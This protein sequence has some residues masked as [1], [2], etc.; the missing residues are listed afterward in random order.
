M[1]GWGFKRKLAGFWAGL[2]LCLGVD[3]ISKNMLIINVLLTINK[4]GYAM[5]IKPK[6]REISLEMA[7]RFYTQ[8]KLAEVIGINPVAVSLILNGKNGVSQETAEKI[9]N[10]FEKSFDQL[11][12]LDLPFSDPLPEV[13]E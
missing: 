1:F 13:V 3:I 4:K 6:V 5:K 7:R 11:F 2:F 10:L 12:D 9:C 8:K